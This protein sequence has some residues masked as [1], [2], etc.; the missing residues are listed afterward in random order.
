MRKREVLRTGGW[1]SYI[2]FN[3]LDQGM[4]S[5]HPSVPASTRPCALCLST[6]N[7]ISLFQLRLFVKR[8]AV[9]AHSRTK[10][11][12]EKTGVHGW[13]GVDPKRADRQQRSVS[14]SVY[15]ITTLFSQAERRML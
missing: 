1:V 15:T 9:Y 2:S 11:S 3:S 13:C 5:P 4:G 14:G 6:V 8:R 7:S 10:N 12:K